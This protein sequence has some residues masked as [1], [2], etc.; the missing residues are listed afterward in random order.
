MTIDL[1]DDLEATILVLGRA[2]EAFERALD[3]LK[4]RRDIVAQA[5]R[6]AFTPIAADL[7]PAVTDLHAGR[8]GSPG[9]EDASK[10]ER[11]LAA[12]SGLAVSPWVTDHPDDGLQARV[13]PCES[14]TLDELREL[15]G[16]RGV[17]VRGYQAALP[18]DE[19]LDRL[20]Q[21]LADGMQRLGDLPRVLRRAATTQRP[22][23]LRLRDEPAE[24]VTAATSFASRLHELGLLAHAR[25]DRGARWLALRTTDA[26]NAFL[27]GSWLSR[28]AAIALGRAREDA[29]FPPAVWRLVDL[30][31]PD[32]SSAR[33]D[34][35]G[36]TLDHRPL[37]VQTQSGAYQEQLTR[38]VHLRRVLRLDPQQCLLVLAG[39]SE[40]ACR[41]LSAIHG[42]SV[43]TVAALDDALRAALS[44]A[45]TVAGRI[46]NDDR[47]PGPSRVATT[48][49]DAG[50]VA[51]PRC[52]GAADF[53]RARSRRRRSSK[54]SS[55]W[56]EMAR[57]WARGS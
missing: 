37:W 15:L 49:R 25:Y 38:C 40:E 18:A 46:E 1:D 14:H 30:H 53:A 28:V 5:A 54:R 4:G 24:V 29:G 21:E 10:L 34:A 16:L 52:C 41:E 31:L 44:P 8:A 56:P 39:A 7:T 55:P 3:E 45:I 6:A 27:A 32:G 2:V 12:T 13:A 57:S 50:E 22:Q 20:A 43:T 48:S 23:T 9:T 35:L 47:C 36:W 19:S 26:G 17:A 33:L 42:L 51:E 11:R